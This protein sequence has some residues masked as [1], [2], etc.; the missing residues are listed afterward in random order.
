[1]LALRSFLNLHVAML[2]SIQG[3]GTLAMEEQLY[4]QWLMILR[5]V[6]NDSLQ[7]HLK[8][9]ID[10]W[11]NGIRTNYS[12]LQVRLLTYVILKLF[13]VEQNSIYIFYNFSA[14]PWRRSFNS[15]PLNA[16]YMRR[17]T[18]SPIRH[19]AITWTNAYLLSIGPSRAKFS[20]LLIKWLNVSETIENRNY[21]TIP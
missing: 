21:F 15:S 17:W 2:A 3:I 7:Y 13:R 6:E 8:Q 16:A 11:P 5:N 10:M 14:I 19:Q 12:S 1:M 18:R 9:P 20:G 4:T